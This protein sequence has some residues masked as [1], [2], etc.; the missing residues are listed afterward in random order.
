V[1]EETDPKDWLNDANERLIKNPFSIDQIGQTFEFRQNGFGSIIWITR[2]LPNP[3]QQLPSQ[4]LGLR[5]QL[6]KG[7]EQG[8]RLVL[9]SAKRGKEINGCRW[10]ITQRLNRNLFIPAQP[11]QFYF[12]I[13]RK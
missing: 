7:T 5:T 6:N 13:E 9:Y 11:E 1:N 2:K 4:V 8:L 12:Q 10:I 3:F